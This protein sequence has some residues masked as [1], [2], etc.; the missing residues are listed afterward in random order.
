[1][2]TV[3][4]LALPGGVVRA[5]GVA[6]DVEDLTAIVSQLAPLSRNFPG[7]QAMVTEL[8]YYQAQANE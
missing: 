2:E 1:M 3:H 6:F 4:N 5:E 7:V 8:K